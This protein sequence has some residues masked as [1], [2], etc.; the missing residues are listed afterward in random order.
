[1]KLPIVIDNIIDKDL[2]EKIKLTL[3][4][5]NFNWFFIS[6]VTHASDNKQ[7]RPGFQHRFVIN[8]KINSDHHDL[9]LPI[10]QNSCKH[11]KYDFKKIIQGRSFLQLPLNITDD[12]IDTPHLDLL[13]KHLV[14]LY[15]VTDADGDTV[16]YK[17]KYNKKSPIPFF[18]DLKELKRVTPKQGRVVLF[19]GSH[20]HTSCQPKQGTRCI[21]NYNV[22]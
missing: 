6:D 11:I 21:I 7:Q 4:S 19:D 10:I 14:I 3:L 15:Y 22:V 1:M 16:I 5:D 9:V 12:K 17:N 18:D 2:Q 8:E 20:W 13:N